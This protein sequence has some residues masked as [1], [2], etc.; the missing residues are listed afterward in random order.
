M[1]EIGGVEG[2]GKKEKEM[3]RLHSP[4]QVSPPGRHKSSDVTNAVNVLA[5]LQ[6][7]AA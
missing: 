6:Y 4:L 7:G 5:C 1:R 3:G 2:E